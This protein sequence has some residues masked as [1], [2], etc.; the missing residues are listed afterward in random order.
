VTP[1]SPILRILSPRN[2][3]GIGVK[4]LQQ[5]K[6]AIYGKVNEIEELLKTIG[7]RAKSHNRDIFS[8]MEV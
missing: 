2:L 6:A 8:W 7:V 1:E 4:T 5:E 3:S